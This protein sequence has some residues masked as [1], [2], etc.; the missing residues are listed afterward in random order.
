MKYTDL[1][2]GEIY[3]GE[4]T[5]VE[6]KWLF[7]YTPFNRSK[8]IKDILH[9]KGMAIL[10]PDGKLRKQQSL[11]AMHDGWVFSIPTR[12]QIQLI[13]KENTYEIY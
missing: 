4:I 11:Y 3:I 1:V 6:A 5:G 2:P 7:R 12:E 9:H 8:H 13:I 10:L